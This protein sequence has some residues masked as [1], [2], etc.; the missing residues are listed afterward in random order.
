[1]LNLKVSAF[2]IPYY[3]Y[4]KRWQQADQIKKKKFLIWTLLRFTNITIAQSNEK[5]LTDFLLESEL[6][7]R[8][9]LH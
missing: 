5:F 6:N 2:L 9:I 3:S 8:P 1:V 7:S 4:T